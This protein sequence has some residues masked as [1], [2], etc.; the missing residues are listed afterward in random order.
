MLQWIFGSFA[1][2]LFRKQLNILLDLT[3]FFIRT[4][5]ALFRVRSPKHIKPSLSEAD[6]VSRVAG[7]KQVVLEFA[8]AFGYIARNVIDKKELEDKIY[9]EK[10]TSEELAGEIHKR[11]AEVPGIHLGERPNGDG[12]PFDVKLPFSMC[13]RHIY[14]IGKSGCGKTNLIRSMILQSAYYGRGVGVL[15][16]EA[17]LLEAEILPYIPENRI[18]DVIYIDPSDTSSPI[19]FN[20]LYIDRGEDRKDGQ[21]N[22]IDLKVDDCSDSLQASYG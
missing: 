9:T 21:D 8:E 10:V 11:I 13:D 4:M 1:G 12:K 2:W 16:P 20:P 15:A 14:L 19:G 5:K 3:M 17:E 7:C 6:E 18:D 22:G